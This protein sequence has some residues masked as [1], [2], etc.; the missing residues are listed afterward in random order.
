MAQEGREMNKGDDRKT[1]LMY[2]LLYTC[3]CALL[4]VP[5]LLLADV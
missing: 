3:N 5:A 1:D 4:T 2:V